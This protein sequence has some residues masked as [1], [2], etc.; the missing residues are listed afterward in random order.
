MFDGQAD[1]W[2]CQAIAQGWWQEI[3]WY[4]DDLEEAVVLSALQAKWQ[5][6]LGE[7]FFGRR[8]PWDHTSV[9]VPTAAHVR[10][11]TEACGFKDQSAACHIQRILS[12]RTGHELVSCT[13]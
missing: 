11:A 4:L 10:K 9:T 8:Q 1:P 5:D 2:C 7:G 12:T 3:E 6:P 13:W